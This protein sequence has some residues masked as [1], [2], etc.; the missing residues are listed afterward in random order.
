MKIKLQIPNNCDFHLKFK[1]KYLLSSWTSSKIL[2]MNFK[3]PYFYCW[4]PFLEQTIKWAII[5]LRTYGK[6][7]LFFSRVSAHVTIFK[8]IK[9]RFKIQKFC[10]FGQLNCFYHEKVLTIVLVIKLKY[11][12]L[13]HIFKK[14]SCGNMRWLME[15]NKTLVQWADH[16]TQVCFFG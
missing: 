9:N 13:V 10:S 11:L 6:F 4:L 14:K 16:T 3:L 12:E 2:C 8:K 7:S 5:D 15:E 1:I